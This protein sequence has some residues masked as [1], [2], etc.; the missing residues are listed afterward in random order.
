MRWPPSSPFRSRRRPARSRDDPCPAGV[1]T[2]DRT[3]TDTVGLVVSVHTRTHGLP[4]RRG[5][6][7][8]SDSRA[9][10]AVD[11][12][13]DAMPHRTAAT[14]SRAQWLREAAGHEVGTGMPSMAAPSGVA[15]TPRR[16]RA[17]R[18]RAVRRA[19]T[20]ARAAGTG[21][22]PARLRSPRVPCGTTR[23][24]GADRARLSGAPGRLAGRPQRLSARHSGPSRAGS[25]MGA[26]RL[27]GAEEGVD[28]GDVDPEEQVRVAGPIARPRSSRPRTRSWIARTRA[29][30][31][32]ASSIVP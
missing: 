12:W 26:E 10:R 30:A 19:A 9:R 8:P 22:L 21:P 13:P 14:P 18:S 3:A 16:R 1:G 23:G 31:A 11:V 28:L 27:V 15:V 24:R 17:S 2:R 20:A 4:F 5:A 7:R 29:M 25:G 6:S 32:S